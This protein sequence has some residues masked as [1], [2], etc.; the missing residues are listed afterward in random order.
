[1]VS[2]AGFAGLIL[3]LFRIRDPLRENVAAKT[4]PGIGAGDR[5]RLR[6]EG[7]GKTQWPEVG[8]EF[9]RGLFAFRHEGRAKNQVL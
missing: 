3:I 4:D 2:S 9:R 1:M 7:R 6:V 8:R 5:S